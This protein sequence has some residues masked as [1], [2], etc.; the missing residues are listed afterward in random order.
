M[1][2]ILIPLQNQIFLVNVPKLNIS[3]FNGDPNN[4]LDYLIVL[5]AS[6][7]SLSTTDKILYLK[8]FLSGETYKT[9]AGITLKEESCLNL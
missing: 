3:A 4:F 8:S 9:I 2:P 7:E 1:F 6:N 5:K